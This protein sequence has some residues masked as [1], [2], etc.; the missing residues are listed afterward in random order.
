[1]YILNKTQFDHA[2]ERIQQST[3]ELYQ[4]QE[5]L[6]TGKQI[7]RPSDDPEGMHQVLNY[8]T[9]LSNIG[10]YSE[11][12]D[13]GQKWCQATNDTLDTV[14]KSL[15]R[16][17]ELAM[18]QVD[19]TANEETRA[20]SATEVEGIYQD[21][22][23]LANTKHEG[24]YLFAPE[25]MDTPPF[26]PDTV[27]NDPSPDNPPEFLMRIRIGDEKEVQI[28]TS[29]DVFTGGEEGK[30]LFTVVD[31]LKTSLENNDVEAIE[32]AFGEIDEALSQV[33]Q[34]QGNI[35]A[36]M[37]R[38][39]RTQETLNKL[40]ELTETSLSQREDADLVEKSI[41]FITKSNN[42]SISLATLGKIL[43]TNLLDYLG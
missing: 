9:I 18:T 34:W 12:I 11:N 30:N 17:R 20:V 27:M 37:Q 39:D 38:F 31:Q 21:L 13:F 14:S 36:K 16:C 42:H 41:E 25:S 1:M 6:S 22:L 40:K 35:G 23:D 5:V 26:D 2:Q 4:L 19:S 15:L 32:A 8:R 29:K 10:Q 24:R 28:N 7:N 43:N 33:T 3:K